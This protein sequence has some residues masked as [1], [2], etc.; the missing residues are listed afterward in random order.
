MGHQ[1][2]DQKSIDLRG[3]W[4]CTYSASVA[5]AQLGSAL[6]QLSCL[7]PL[8]GQLGAMSCLANT[9]FGIVQQP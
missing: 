5:T 4:H 1:A 7:E 6:A 3:M 9:I 8:W 2:A